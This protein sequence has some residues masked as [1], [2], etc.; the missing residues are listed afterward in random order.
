MSN[1]TVLFWAFVAPVLLLIC[2]SINP[3]LGL[4]ALLIG[5]IRLLNRKDNPKKDTPIGLPRNV[6]N[7]PPLGQKESQAPVNY[8]STGQA[9]SQ[10]YTPQRYVGE[11]SRLNWAGFGEQIEISGLIVREPLIY[12]TL[13]DKNIARQE[14]SCITLNGQ[15]DTITAPEG[16]G[17]WPTFIEASPAQRGYYLKWLAS[18]KNEP[19]EDI[20]YAFLYFYG[21][22]RRA[23]ID[24]KDIPQILDEVLR[25]LQIYPTSRSFR[26]YL[27]NF[28]TYL[29]M[30]EKALGHSIDAKSILDA[31]PDTNDELLIEIRAIEN[32]NG[33]ALLTPDI[34]YELTSHDPRATNS[35]VVERVNEQFQ[36]LFEKKY[37]D[38]FGAGI[39]LEPTKDRT[40]K[41][42]PASPTLAYQ[43]SEW[44]S[45]RVPNILG[46]KKQFTPLVKIWNECIEELR[47]LSRAIQKGLAPDSREL[48]QILPEDLKEEYEHP[49]QARWNAIFEGHMRDDGMVFVPIPNLLPLT[50]VVSTE[51]LTL[52]QSKD[53]AQAAEHVG[54]FI[55]P[56]ARQA[57]RAYSLDTQV[58]LIKRNRI[59]PNTVRDTNPSLINVDELLLKAENT[60]YKGRYE[61]LPTNISQLLELKNEIALRKAAT[62]GGSAKSILNKVGFAIDKKLNA[63]QKDNNYELAL[64]MLELGMVIASA[65]KQIDEDELE[66]IAN[67]LSSHFRLGHIESYKLEVYRELLRIQPPT[68]AGIVKKL[69]ASLTLDQVEL[70]L[71]F[72]VGVAAANGEIVSSEVKALERIYAALGVDTAKLDTLIQ[73]LHSLDEPVE[74]RKEIPRT[75]GE[76]LPEIEKPKQESRV[77]LN[78]EYLRQILDE[79]AKVTSILA[80]A[81]KE[82]EEDF[83]DYAPSPQ[84]I[85]LAR[86][87]MEHQWLST[88]DKKYH[89]ALAELVILQEWNKQ[90]FQAL[91]RKH[92]LMPDGFIDTINSWSDEHLGDF[93]IEE[94]ASIKVNKNL[95]EKVQ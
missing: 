50:G 74:I 2:F 14:A 25:L 49:D 68:L 11:R 78:Q 60:D 92:G 1:W 8:P 35:V 42:R 16:L 10:K 12:W 94:G 24:K 3:V 67:F 21:L 61:L 30:R 7:N 18:G 48:Y 43:A 4:L 64:M 23:L 6:Q 82:S 81:I 19:L 39:T 13:A 41:Y 26:S 46:S 95:L 47:P 65:D 37:R 54:L 90:E 15:I 62:A 87:Q 71:Q 51:K 53:L 79:T 85:G 57:L 83:E 80:E 40:F 56:D 84:P 66:Q 72:L 22:E 89:E 93:L 38:A 20:G 52:K 27:G 59:P 34:A 29:V 31:L 58:A 28:V 77:K 17:Y 32:L 36:Q 44:Q 9:Q 86:S 63:R 70:L 69:K 5:G 73:K 91:A 45:L 33:S 75:A 55:L 88:L 76:A